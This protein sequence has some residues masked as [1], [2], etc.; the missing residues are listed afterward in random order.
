MKSFK[1][2]FV[3]TSLI[4]SSASTRSFVRQHTVTSEEAAASGKALVFYLTLSVLVDSYSATVVIE[5]ILSLF[6]LC[7]ISSGSREEVMATEGAPD[8][9]VTY[10][11]ISGERSRGRLCT[12]VSHSNYFPFWRIHS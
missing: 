3:K 8:E 4:K 7:L 6:F 9:Q 1:A 5:S 12:L 2:M 10:S 11:A